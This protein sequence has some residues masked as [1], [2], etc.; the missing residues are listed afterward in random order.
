MEGLVVVNWKYSS[1]DHND[2]EYPEKDGELMKNLLVEGGY[3]DTVV[4]GNKEDIAKVV[5]DFI[6]NHQSPLEMS[7]FHYS[8]EYKIR[9]VVEHF[10]LGHGIYN[11]AVRLDK[12]N[13]TRKPTD[14][15]FETV[16]ATDSVSHGECIIGTSGNLYPVV[17]LKQDPGEMCIL[18]C[19]SGYV[20]E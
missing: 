7:H 15:G 2:L 13:Y 17:E 14:E 5:K 3:T 1:A 16:N 20:Q 19:H 8:G 6:E 9:I 12:H 4:V 18:D 11:A 10:L